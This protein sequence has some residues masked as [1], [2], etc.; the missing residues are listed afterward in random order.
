MRIG[1][2]ER[3]A[4]LL[5]PKTCLWN[6]TVLLHL[7]S[8][9][10]G[11]S[12]GWGPFQFSSYCPPAA[13]KVAPATA[14]SKTCGPCSKVGSRMPSF[15]AGE[16]RSAV[17][18]PAHSAV[19]NA[20]WDFQQVTE[21]K[22]IPW[23]CPSHATEGRAT[24]SGHRCPVWMRNL[25]FD[26]EQTSLLPSQSME[27]RNS[28]YCNHSKVVQWWKWAWKMWNE[29][30]KGKDERRT[31]PFT[32]VGFYQRRCSWQSHSQWWPRQKAE[33]SQPALLTLILNKQA[34]LVPQPLSYQA[35]HFSL[36][37][38]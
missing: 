32:L 34:R 12:G 23:R 10:K 38:I 17:P 26:P 27:H 5:F 7:Q 22:T 13:E 1:G 9:F 30:G 16:G 14:G 19:G 28:P 2:K 29:K 6:K 8:R 25:G 4:F 11:K 36:L 31:V 20:A 24:I 37:H 15:S 33:L 18:S 3:T 21:V 35:V